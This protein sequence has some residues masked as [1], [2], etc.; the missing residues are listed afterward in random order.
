MNILTKIYQL[1]LDK[2]SIILIMSDHG[3]SVGEKFGERAYGAYCYDY[4][5]RNFAYF[6]IPDF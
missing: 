5:L 1:E 4:T 6:L 3:V 2:D